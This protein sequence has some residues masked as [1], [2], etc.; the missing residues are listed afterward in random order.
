[1]K[2]LMHEKFLELE[3]RNRVLDERLRQIVVEAGESISPE[4]LLYLIESKP[5]KGQAV[6]KPMGEATSHY[7]N[8]F[9]LIDDCG[10]SQY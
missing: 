8:L 6:I 4:Y 7:Y 2:S 9:F 3:E 5:N 10:K 1:M